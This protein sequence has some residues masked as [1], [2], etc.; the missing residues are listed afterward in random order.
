[1]AEIQEG[2]E[3]IERLKESHEEL[4]NLLEGKKK[5]KE[6]LNKEIQELMDRVKEQDKE[7]QSLVQLLCSIEGR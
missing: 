3:S 6:Q 5:E 1:M 4:V 2:E 7:I